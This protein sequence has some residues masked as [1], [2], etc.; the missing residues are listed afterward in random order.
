MGLDLCEN[1][2]N[3]GIV[4]NLGKGEREPMG[5]KTSQRKFGAI[6]L[7]FYNDRYCKK[8]KISELFRYELLFGINVEVTTLLKIDFFE[9]QKFKERSVFRLIQVR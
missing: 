6:F 7:R 8:Y 3:L 4:P 2:T 1:V 9:G 5:R